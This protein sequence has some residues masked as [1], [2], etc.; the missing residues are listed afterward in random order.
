M[1]I[2]YYEIS[3]AL[4]KYTITTYED[5]VTISYKNLVKD[6]QREFK[7]TELVESNRGK[8]GAKEWADIGAG[9]IAIAF[10][11]LVFLSFT[12]IARTISGTLV[13]LSLIP[14]ALRFIKEEWVSFYKPN[15]EFAFA[16]KITKRN[17][18]DAEKVI[19]FIQDKISPAK[20]KS[21][22]KSNKSL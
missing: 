11:V 2:V 19:K 16:I 6:L 10:L 8:F 22:R 20:P 4:S 12:I 7:Y 17:K 5:K 9:L 3:D 15:S 18:E 13:I 21:K 14:F 1:Q